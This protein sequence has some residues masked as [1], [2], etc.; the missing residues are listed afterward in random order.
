MEEISYKQAQ[1]RYIRVF[2]P[3][4]VVYIILCFAGPVLIGMVE[5]QPV[6]LKPVIAFVT[7]APIA[8]VFWLLLRNIRQT[9]EYT[10][11]QMVGAILPAAAITLTLTTF[12]GFMELYGV[13][14]LPERVSAT[15]FV[16]PTFFGL[17]CAFHCIRAAREQ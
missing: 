6:W 14:S 17:W 10:R 11:S 8:I 4:M 5:V 7:A 1:Q 13:V 2:W 12:W 15:F 3:V 16:S 9:D